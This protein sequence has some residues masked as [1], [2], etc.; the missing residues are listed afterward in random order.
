MNDE[1]EKYII[2]IKKF[3]VIGQEGERGEGQNSHGGGGSPLY[4]RNK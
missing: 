4:H 3:F 1:V 2:K